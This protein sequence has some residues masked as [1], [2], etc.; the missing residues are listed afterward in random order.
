M[1]LLGSSFGRALAGA[2]EG[3]ASIAGKYLDQQLVMD[4]A[5]AL[6]ELRVLSEQRMDEY[7]NSP[8]RRARLREEELKDS[9]AKYEQ[10]IMQ[11]IGE[12]KNTELLQA[13]IERENKLNEGTAG[14]RAAVEGV[15]TRTKGLNTPQVLSPGQTVTIGGETVAENSRPT[16]AEASLTAYREGKG[17]VERMSEGAKVQL[18]ALDKREAGIAEL[19]DKG[20]SSGTLSTS[21]TGPDGKPAP[22][23]DQFR[24]LRSQQAQIALQRSRVLA[25]EGLL[26]GSEDADRLLAGGAT[27]ADLEASVKQADQIGGRYAQDFR[28]A[29]EPA[30]KHGRSREYAME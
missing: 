30:L 1:G 3:V 23:H 12:L 16:P 14:S 28:A 17:K 13:T 24:W 10:S 15:L 18:Q 26:D 11:R 6:E 22:G 5:R 2:G 4:K 21:A 7:R 27:A 8:Q 25:N 29:I 9:S 19:I 20:V